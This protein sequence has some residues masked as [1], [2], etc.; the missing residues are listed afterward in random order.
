MSYTRGR[1]RGFA[2]LMV[3]LFAGASLRL[4]LL[5]V[6]DDTDCCPRRA[7]V[8]ESLKAP[9]PDCCSWVPD[10][11]AHRVALPLADGRAEDVV[12]LEAGAVPAVLPLVA[13]GAAAL[14]R[15]TRAPPP[16]YARHMA[17]LL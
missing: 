6:C 8:V 7:V 11:G 4:S 15:P 9:L 13:P 3:V 2:A 10:D 14:A 1:M 16:L 12:A 17:R 5:T